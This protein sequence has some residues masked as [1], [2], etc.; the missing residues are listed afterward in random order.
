LKCAEEDRVDLIVAGTAA[1]SGPE[2]L[3]LGSNAAELIRN[4][5][6]PVLTVGPRVPEPE[7]GP[8]RFRDIVVATDFSAEAAK[9]IQLALSFAQ[10]S[11]AH[12]YLCY[13]VSSHAVGTASESM[14]DAFR[15]ALERLIPESCRERCSPE[16]VVEHGDAG[17]GVLELA[18]RVKADLIV[19]GARKASFWLMH[20]ERGLTPDLLAEATC[21]VLTVP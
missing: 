4:A 10:D 8:L 12:I 2:R 17:R 11:R 7:E 21:P 9:A 1:K 14:D 19:L 5:R 3:V 20:V 6:C 13:V 18:K 16:C 15:S